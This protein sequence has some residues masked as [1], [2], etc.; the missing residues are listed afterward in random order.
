MFDLQTKIMICIGSSLLIATIVLICIVIC[1][2]FKVSGEL[3]AAKKPDAVAV[4]NRSEVARDKAKVNQCK[5]I[6]TESCRALQCCDQCRLYGNCDSLP[7]CCCDI[8]EGL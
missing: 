2:Y 7:S 8:N 5:V 6:P 4:N 3:K 1:L